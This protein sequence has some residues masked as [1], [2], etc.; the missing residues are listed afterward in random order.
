[1]IFFCDSNAVPR[2]MYDM[3]PDVVVHFWWLHLRIVDDDFCLYI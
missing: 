3:L 1:M 2:S